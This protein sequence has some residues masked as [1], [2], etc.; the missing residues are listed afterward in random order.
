MT[1]KSYEVKR[2]SD[3][4]DSTPICDLSD[5]KNSLDRLTNYLA[6]DG[7]KLLHKLAKS[8][9]PYN[10]SVSSEDVV[11]IAITKAI[12][13][14]RKHHSFAAIKEFSA[15][16]QGI[17]W[18]ISNTEIRK[19]VQQKQFLE[20][21]RNELTICE[22][23]DATNQTDNECFIRNAL[24]LLPENERVILVCRY[25]L[26]Y[27]RPKVATILEVTQATIRNREI[28]AIKRI[29]SYFFKHGID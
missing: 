17:L 28:R 22:S 1:G 7:E 29:N 2:P 10:Q 8:R 4:P 12:E 6:G 15:W 27:S 14:Y 18:N 13:Y 26:G 11:E 21:I 5:S 3:S 9:F 23:T 19:V 25:F 20:A 16:M 24:L